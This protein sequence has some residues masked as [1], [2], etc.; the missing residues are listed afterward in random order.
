MGV[1]LVGREMDCHLGGGITSWKFM[2]ERELT[3]FFEQNLDQVNDPGT[4]DLY[5]DYLHVH[6]WTMVDKKHQ[7]LCQSRN[8]RQRAPLFFT[9]L[10]CFG[11]GCGGCFGTG[12]GVVVSDGG[13]G[14][15]AASEREPST[16]VPSEAIGQWP[17]STAGTETTARVDTGDE[18]EPE[19]TGVSLPWAGEGHS[20]RTVAVAAGMLSGTPDSSVWA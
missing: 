10:A 15:K 1:D 12:G 8:H 19:V 5:A 7:M 14:G 17:S 11:A 13:R 2:M 6:T 4:K 9:R 16:P 20:A 3:A 18:D